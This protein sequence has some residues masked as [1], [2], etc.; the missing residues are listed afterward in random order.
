MAVPTSWPSIVTLSPKC[1]LA[2]FCGSSAKTC[3]VVSSYS[4]SGVPDAGAVHFAASANASS[5]L[6]DA[7]TITPDQDS[8]WDPAPEMS[9]WPA[10][11][12]LAAARNATA[13]A[14]A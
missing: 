4:A 12:I 10:P 9:D 2:E 8:D 6:H 14:Q 5:A 7:L 11:A 1:P 13:P 3:R